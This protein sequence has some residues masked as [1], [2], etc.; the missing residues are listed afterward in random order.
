M[1]AGVDVE[2]LSAR[3][4]DEEAHGKRKKELRGPG[5]PAFKELAEKSASESWSGAKG[6]KE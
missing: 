1:G 5:I 3:S 2:V 6:R 4:V